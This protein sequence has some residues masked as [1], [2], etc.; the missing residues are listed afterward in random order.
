MAD[1]RCAIWGMDHLQTVQAVDLFLAKGYLETFL[2]GV[3]EWREESA[4]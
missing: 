4:E 3:V 1:L 2:K